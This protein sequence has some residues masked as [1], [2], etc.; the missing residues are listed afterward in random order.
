MLTRHYPRGTAIVAANNN[1]RRRV[2][3]WVARSLH[4]PCSEVHRCRATE[5]QPSSRE[6]AAVRDLCC[7]GACKS[8]ITV[9]I[10]ARSLPPLIVQRCPRE[11]PAT[12]AK[13]T[14]RVSGSFAHVVTTAQDAVGAEGAR[15]RHLHALSGGARKKQHWRK[16]EEH[17]ACCLVARRAR[18]ANDWRPV[19]NG[20]LPLTHL[21]RRRTSGHSAFHTRRRI[22]P[23]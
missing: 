4:P 1:D 10:G 17:D 8:A 12:A 7:K 9:I 16:H 18:E 2:A 19:G 6:D 14:N 15:V 13:T 21:S 5:L 23:A 20:P 11:A 22:H 3:V